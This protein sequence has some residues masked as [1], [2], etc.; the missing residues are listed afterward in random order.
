MAASILEENVKISPLLKS[1]TRTAPVKADIWRLRCEKEE[2]IEINNVLS[3]A[4]EKN[5]QLNSGVKAMVIEEL[6]EIC[7]KHT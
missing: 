1:Q 7:R 5:S 2:L 6:A 3:D 4:L